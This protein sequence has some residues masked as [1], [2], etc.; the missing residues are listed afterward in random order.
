[1]TTTREGKKQWSRTRVLQRCRTCRNT[2][3]QTGFRRRGATPPSFKVAKGFSS[4]VSAIAS[5][6]KR[7]L[8]IFATR[9][10]CTCVASARLEHRN[11]PPWLHVTY[12]YCGVQCGVRSQGELLAITGNARRRMGSKIIIINAFGELLDV[13]PDMESRGWNPVCNSTLTSPPNFTARPKQSPKPAPICQ[14]IAKATFSKPRLS[15][16][17]QRFACGTHP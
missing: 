14:A 9:V 3:S 17:G 15:I 13:R 11:R 1:M 10:K 12:Y 8:L 5:T 16:S 6:R 7:R 2:K 4:A